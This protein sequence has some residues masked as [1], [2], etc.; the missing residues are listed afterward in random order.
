MQMKSNSNPE[1]STGVD[2]GMSILFLFLGVFAGVLIL[3]SIII[4]SYCIHRRRNV[5]KQMNNGIKLILILPNL[6]IYNLIQLVVEYT[7]EPFYNYEK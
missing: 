1:K 5:N 3:T 2:R 7:M 6:R 4:V